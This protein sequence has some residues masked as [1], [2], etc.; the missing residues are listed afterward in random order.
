[1]RPSQ[2]Y[3]CTISQSGEVKRGDRFEFGRNWQQFLQFVDDARIAH[4]EDSLKQMLGI[5]TLTGC[6]FLDVGAGSGLFSLA[7][8]KLGARVHSFD[9]DPASVACTRE[10]K[11]R[12]FPQDQT[13]SID[14][15]SILDETYVTRLGSFDIVYSWGVL[16][17]TGDMW[18]SLDFVHALVAGNGYLFISIYNDQGGVSRRWRQI[19]HL[20]NRSPGW[21]RLAMVVTVGTWWESR[22]ALIR[23]VRFQNP[24]PF[25][26]W[27]NKKRDRGMS[28]WYD[29]VDW[30]GG[31]PF[32]FAKPEE[33]FD[34]FQQRSFQ[35]RRLKTVLCGHG[36]NEYVFRKC[37]GT[38]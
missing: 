16:H 33:V 22:A 30:V 10:L 7:A 4:A 24:L 9:Y 1:M 20:Y 29:L 21:M 25:A 17:Q 36:C 5:T 3:E 34:F 23:L 35:L 37:S 38:K 19:K 31:Y 11:R 6:S 15:A 12:Y 27:A 2:E 8:K 18:K 26:D 14:E 28:V 32:E 13:W